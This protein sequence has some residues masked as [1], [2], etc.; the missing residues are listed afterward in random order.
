MLGNQVEV[1]ELQFEHLS[2]LA[3][4]VLLGEFK[5]DIGELLV[6]ASQLIVELLLALFIVYALS[7]AVCLYKFENC[8]VS[9]L[10]SVL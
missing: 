2:R 6:C 10:T 1:V 5:L 4:S 8:F 9:D 7:V 3:E